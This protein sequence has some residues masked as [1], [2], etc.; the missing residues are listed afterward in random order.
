MVKKSPQQLYKLGQR[1]FTAEDFCRHCVVKRKHFIQ[2]KW[3][4]LQRQKVHMLNG[5][6]VKLLFVTDAEHAEI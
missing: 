6:Q 5:P 3:G 2:H 4:K 1:I